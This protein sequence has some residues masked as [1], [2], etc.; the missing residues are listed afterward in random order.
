MK[1]NTK[2]T[3]IVT[4]GAS[5]IG[6][7]IVKKFAEEGAYVIAVDL[8]IET[9]DAKKLKTNFPDSLLFYKCDVTN[10]KGVIKCVEYAII[11][12]GSVDVLINNAGITK[13]AVIWKMEEAEWDDVIN[14][15]LKGAFNFVRCL[16][17]HFKERKE[18][19]IVSISSINGLRGKF[20]QSNYSASKAGL[21][22]FTKAIAKEL[23]KYNV[24][25]N[26]V[27]PGMVLTPMAE[28]LPEEIK[29]RAL[30]EMVLKR[31]SLPEDIASVTYFLC[32]EAA[33]QITGSVIKVDGGQYI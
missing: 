18:G 2:K 31:F 24:N 1:N 7:S 29:N 32:T 14:V 8:N 13:D 23:G 33:R 28:K 22:G 20:G 19:K 26:A 27:A 16:S 25:V 5:G 30:D 9:E 6:I 10:F 15:N 12:A 3:V 4:G 17:P 11:E 21:I